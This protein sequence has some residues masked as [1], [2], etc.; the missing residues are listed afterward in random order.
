MNT[1]RTLLSSRSACALLLVSLLFLTQGRAQ[2]NRAFATKGCTEVGGSVS[3]QSITPVINGANGTS[4]TIL[5]VS[6]FIGYFIADGFELGFDPFSVAYANSSGHS[7]TSVMILVAPSY[8]FDLH[9]KAS[10]FIEALVGLS[11]QS[12]GSSL[13]GL[14]WGGRA[15]VKIGVTGKSLLNIGIE[16]LQITLD[17]EG[18]TKRFGTNQLT[19]SAGFTVWF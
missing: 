17:P 15:G 12:N 3:L 5:T 9:D 13:S 7:S 4:T 8:N 6:P 2:E 10:P 14:T 1:Y 16:Y 11:S 19:F 18:A